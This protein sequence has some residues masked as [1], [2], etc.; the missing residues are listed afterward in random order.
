[1][2]G[3]SC[4]RVAATVN[5]TREA[6]HTSDFALDLEDGVNWV[7]DW[8]EYCSVRKGTRAFGGRTWA[9]C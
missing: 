9:V 4:A 2:H 7:E 6:A 3:H 5:G 1:M 8:R